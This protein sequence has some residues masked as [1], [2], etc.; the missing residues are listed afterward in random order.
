MKFK[1]ENIKEVE[2]KA[3]MAKKKLQELRDIRDELI[4][5]GCSVELNFCNGWNIDIEIKL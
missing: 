1:S 4:G 3:E 5:L 2:E